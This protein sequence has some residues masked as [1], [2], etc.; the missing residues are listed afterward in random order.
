MLEKK[1]NKESLQLVQ[2]LRLIQ[3]NQVLQHLPVQTNES[4][5]TRYSL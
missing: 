1:Y 2:D 3:I 5:N 4:A